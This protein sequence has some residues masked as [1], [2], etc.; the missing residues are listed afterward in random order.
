[1]EGC[2]AKA[3]NV[4]SLRWETAEGMSE[5]SLPRLAVPW[6]RDA[7]VG[8]DTMGDSSAGQFSSPALNSRRGDLEMSDALRA[9]LEGEVAMASALLV[10]YM[11][12]CW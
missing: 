2:F 9:D 3:K 10:V 7:G 1:M 6:E 8:V 4:S 12:I 11:M 5:L